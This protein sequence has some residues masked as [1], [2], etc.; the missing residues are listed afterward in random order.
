MKYEQ[1]ALVL[2]HRYS[3]AL[4]LLLLL[5]IPR[6][7]YSQETPTES[8]TPHLNK[9][10]IKGFIMVLPI[11]SYFVTGI[12]AGYE[13]SISKHSVL[14]LGSYYFFNTDEMGGQYHTICVMPAY[15]FY[16]V[17]EKRGLNNLWISVYLSYRI[18][19][20]TKNEGG[21]AWHTLY[22]YGIG[23]SI[24]KKM[25]LSKSKRLFLDLG[26]GVAYNNYFSDPIFSDTEW[27][28]K[29]IGKTVSLRPILQVGLKF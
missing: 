2:R 11:P 17:S 19:I 1:N 25:F 23:G 4:I 27:K 3:K 7:F 24:G 29:Y 5:I 15:K 12:S 13:R 22:Y 8:V 20:E 28:D 6:F 9:N 26:F 10:A 18:E 14:E 21:N 16:T